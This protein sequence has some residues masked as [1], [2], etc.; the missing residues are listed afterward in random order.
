MDQR[1]IKILFS[2]FWGPQGW[3]RVGLDELSADDYAYAKSQGVLFD[4]IQI[5]HDE[6]VAKAIKAHESVSERAVANA[7]VQSLGNRNLA[8][9]S[10]LGT[11]SFLSNFPKHQVS[12]DSGRC[13]VCG[14]YDPHG[15]EKQDL[16][17]LNFERLKWGG[18]RHLQPLYAAFDL[19]QFLK[20]PPIEPDSRDVR[21]L[22]NVFEAVESA[23]K[24]T[25]SAMLQA[26]LP[27]DLRSNKSERDILVGILG[28]CGVLE[29]PIRQGFLNA[30][31]HSRL[32]QFPDRRFVDMPYPACWWNKSDGVN[33]QVVD[34]LFGHLL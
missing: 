15:K 12:I 5:A 21:I 33:H 7:F 25:S 4:P 19:E 23:P 34:R 6:L 16:N 17:A 20:L 24:G 29:T 11:Y 13:S 2:A 14:A 31:T 30:F 10:A 8:M 27:K 32:Q 1:A 28:I 3:K 26:H 22:K 18:V 9:R